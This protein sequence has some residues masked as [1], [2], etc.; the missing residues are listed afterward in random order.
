MMMHK[1]FSGQ[2]KHGKMSLNR[3]WAGLP[4]SRSYAC[5]CWD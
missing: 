3:G 2:T 4:R 5:F 1:F